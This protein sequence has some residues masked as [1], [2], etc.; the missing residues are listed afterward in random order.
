MAC[1][2][3]PLSVIVPVYNVEPYLRRCL[4]SIVHQTRPVQEIICVDDG[5]TDG[6]LAILREYERAYENLHVIHKENGG[7]VS[8]RKAGLALATCPYAA[9][10]DSDDFVE[11]EM[12]EDLMQQIM[13]ADA[14][15][16]TSGTI[17]DYGTHVVRTREL[18]KAGCYSGEEL[19]ALR[20]SILS[21][22]RFFEMNLTIHTWDKIYRTELLR[23]FQQ[24]LDDRISVAE[25]VAV[26]WPVLLHAKRICVSGKEYYHYCLRNDSIMGVKPKGDAA[27]VRIC[28][29]TLQQRLREV[30]DRVPNIMEQF[31][32]LRAYVLLL[33]D[34][35]LVLKTEGEHL[36]PFGRVPQQ[37]RIALYGAGKF[38]KELKSWLDR[39]G[40]HVACWVDKAENRAGVQNP[41][42]L[43]DAAYDIV[44]IAALQADAVASIEADLRRLGIPAEKVR[45]VEVRELLDKEGGRA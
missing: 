11:P 29:E 28:L 19:K 10:V 17:R 13:Q 9:Y 20:S 42:V 31:A 15:V 6:S 32:M 36:H 35:D 18:T 27:Q 41:A 1:F 8:A 30:Q 25:D 14:D 34:A 23:T 21:T 43:E 2:C 7:L 37:A 45:K 33:R 24:D 3:L 39:H 4:D 12:Y 26:A 16:V 38:G 22:E 5:S 40:C 44:L